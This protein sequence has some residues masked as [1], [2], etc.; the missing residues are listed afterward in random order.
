MICT[1]VN[2]H[3]TLMSLFGFEIF[4]ML[5]ST[6]VFPDCGAG[7]VTHRRESQSL[8]ASGRERGGEQGAGRVRRKDI[9]VEQ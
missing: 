3:P 5:C 4:K 8:L 9:C 2:K 6:S 1:T 7:A